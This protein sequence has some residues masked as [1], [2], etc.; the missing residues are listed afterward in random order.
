MNNSQNESVLP[1][2]LSNGGTAVFILVYMGFPWVNFMDGYAH[3][4]AELMRLNLNKQ[5][6][7]QKG[8]R[9]MELILSVL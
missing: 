4:V 7:Y 1:V 9:A 5:K 3:L 6:Y 8:Q 2:V